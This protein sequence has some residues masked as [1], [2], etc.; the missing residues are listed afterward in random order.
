MIPDWAWG[1]DC[2]ITVCDKDGIIIYMND[3]AVR[4][5]SRHGDLIGRISSTATRSARVKS[6]AACLRAAAATVTR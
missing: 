6:S 3:K 1:L 2:S 4:Q 5:Y